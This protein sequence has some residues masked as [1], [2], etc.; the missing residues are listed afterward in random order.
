MIK[1]DTTVAEAKCRFKVELCGRQVFRDYSILMML[2]KMGDWSVL[3]LGCH[4][5]LSCS[6]RECKIC[7]CG[8]ALSSKPPTRE[9]LRSHLADFVDGMHLNAR[10]T[11]STIIFPISANHITDFW[12]CSCH[13][14]SRFQNS[15]VT[16][17]ISE[18]I[19]AELKS[20]NI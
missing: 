11:C 4:E 9:F 14:R 15:L 1:K 19:G 2:Y 13:Y 10:R 3:S 7:C 18:I 17:I 20:N 6:V 16:Q 8:A 12:G 5:W